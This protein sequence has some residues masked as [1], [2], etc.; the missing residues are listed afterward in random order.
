MKV[1]Y[2]YYLISFHPIG[3]LPSSGTKGNKREEEEGGG[4]MEEV[5]RSRNPGDR[6]KGEGSGRRQG[7]QEPREGTKKKKSGG[8]GGIS[9]RGRE[10]E[11]SF[12]GDSFYI[13]WK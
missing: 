7:V 13:K 8:G 2:L 5:E 1:L 6:R 11:R 12:L 9:D 4:R 10:R 3:L